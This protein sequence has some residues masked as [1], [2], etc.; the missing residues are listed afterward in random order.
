MH[1]HVIFSVLILQPP[2]DICIGGHGQTLRVRFDNAF[3]K[4][5]TGSTNIIQTADAETVITSVYI[6]TVLSV[7]IILATW[8]WLAPWLAGQTGF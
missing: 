4:L 1:C 5:N 3:D 8:P 7:C 2:E 6:H